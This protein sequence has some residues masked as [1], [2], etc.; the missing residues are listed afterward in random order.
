MSKK[1]HAIVVGA[2]IAGLGVAYFL[3]REGMSVTVLDKAD[4]KDNCSFGNAGMIVP[5]H[6]VP[7]ASPGIISKGLRWMLQAESPF[8]I[9][10]RL[11]KDLFKWGWKFRQASTQKHVEESGPLLRDL[12]LANRELLL[13]IER[14]E[15]LE[16]GFKKNGLLNLCRTQEGLE[17]EIEVAEQAN[18]LGIPARVLSAEETR[19]MDPNIEMDIIGSTYFPKDAHLHPGSLL[20]KLKERMRERSVTF[21]YNTNIVGIRE[22]KNKADGVV[23][24]DGEVI[25]GTKI[26]LCPGAWTP[27]LA[28]NTGLVLPM[29]AGKGYSITLGNPESLP[30]ICALLSEAKVSMT[31]MYGKLRFGGTMEIVGID[32]TINPVKLNALKKSA[33]SYFPEFTMEDFE[34]QETWVGLRPISPDGLPYVGSI[35]RYN[36]VYVSTGHA[37]MGMSLGVISGKIVSQ[38]ILEGEAGLEHPL[39]DPDRYA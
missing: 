27:K 11:D 20:N 4:G 31:P 13:E 10:P 35:S 36:N 23:A 1:N 17:E 8:Y 3:S 16:F 18:A 14:K 26:I 34:G 21:R 38:L 6:I 37:M 2:G 33:C 22:E 29:Q 12:L 15:Q 32:T 9:R 28:D 30:E 19:N 5:S 24:A 25:E 39:I 7:L